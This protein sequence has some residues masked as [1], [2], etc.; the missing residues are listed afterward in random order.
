MHFLVYCALF[1]SLTINS[2][3]ANKA[4]YKYIIISFVWTKP[5]TQI[6]KKKTFL[7]A[8]FFFHN[9]VA[10]HFAGGLIR[11]GRQVRTHSIAYYST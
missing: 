8:I 5:I 2:F 9:S 11:G 4:T 10:F 6:R 7:F 3:R 1:F